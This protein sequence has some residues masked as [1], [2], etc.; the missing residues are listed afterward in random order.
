MAIREPKKILPTM[1][2]DSGEND[3]KFIECQAEITEVHDVQ[4]KKFGVKTV[5]NLKNAKQGEFSIF[6]N[7]YSIEKLVAKFGKED[8]AWKGKLVNLKKEKD[9]QFDNE[10]IVAVPV[11]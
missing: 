11:A 10:M 1:K 8:T 7:N 3:L 5:M 4:T 2:I 6:L 9:K